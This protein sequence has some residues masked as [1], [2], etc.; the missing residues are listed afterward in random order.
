MTAFAE[1][2]N[3]RD[4]QLIEAAFE[5][6]AD[7]YPDLS[8][9]EELAKVERLR[10][11]LRRLAGSNIDWRHDDLGR[12]ALLNRF[13]F[14][15]CRFRGASKSYYDPRN[16]YLN[17]VM[18]RRV[19]IPI[20]LSVIYA[21]LGAAL[22]LDMHGVN[23]PGHFVLGVNRDDGP[24]MFIDV[25]NG[26]AVLEWSACRQRV[27]HAMHRR[28]PLDATEFPPMSARDVLA[29]MLRN[30][31]GIYLECDLERAARVQKRLAELLPHDW[32]VGSALA[33][34]YSRTGRPALA[35]QTLQAWLRRRPELES[36]EEF[37]D[38][39]R[40]AARDSALAN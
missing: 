6:A 29:R 5:I 21:E 4:T 20:T 35:L 39:L 37:R 7:E 38:S 17:D 31:K 19:G 2:A 33:D 30:L 13:F 12:I 16:S 27:P 25:F 18:D 9:R 14:D 22:N 36:V 10:Q 11:Q 26:G 23:L 1:I 15:Q 3:G 32:D 40:Q 8:I 24:R 34:L 28:P